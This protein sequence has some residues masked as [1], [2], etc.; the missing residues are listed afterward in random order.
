MQILDT[1]PLL[2]FHLQQQRLIELIRAG[3]IT[4]A[5][6]FAAEDLAP[7]AE[8]HP[9]LLPEL[10]RTMAL[11]AFELPRGGPG[12]GGAAST[13]SGRS[14][15]SRSKAVAAGSAGSALEVPSHIGELLAPAQRLR[16]AGELNSA[17]LASQSQGREPKLPQLLKMMSYGENILTT[18]GRVA[19]PRL[20]LVGA[21]AGDQGA[22]GGSATGPGVGGGSLAVGAAAGNV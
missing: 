4:L 2:F 19:F 8:E 15:S 1:N 11:L 22:T 3:D 12:R 20:D 7:R 5:L 10:E 21:L 18:E 9:D 14:S 16:T 6:R 13:I 17:I